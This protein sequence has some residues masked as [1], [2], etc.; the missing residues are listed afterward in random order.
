MSPASPLKVGVIGPAGF[1][2]SYLCVELLNRGHTVIGISRNPSKL[3]KHE[4]YIPRSVDIDAASIEEI[5]ETFKDL[6]ALVCEFGPHTAGA[7]ALLYSK[8]FQLRFCFSILLRFIHIKLFRSLL[9]R[10]KKKK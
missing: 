4:R 9:I 1:G 6:D 2:G 3:G 7:G 5:A 10:K 8:N